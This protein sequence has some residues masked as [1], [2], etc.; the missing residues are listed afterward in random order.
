MNRLSR[1][2][3]ALLAA[4][5]VVVSLRFPS[6]ALAQQ[7]GEGMDRSGVLDIRSPEEHRVFEAL[8]CT[9]G[10]PREAISTCTC[11]FAAGFRQEVREMMAKGM[12]LEDIKAEWVR[13]HGPEALSVPPNGGGNRFVYI[14]PLLLIAGM[15][16]VAI[17]ALRRFRAHEVATT[18]AAT[19]KKGKIAPAARDDY[20]QK[21]DDELKRLD[22]DDDE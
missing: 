2:I 8:Q 19:G 7:L 13:R 1:A 16:A 15:A 5:A 11:G 17:S 12:S 9:C 14:V 4:A 3:F 6:L 22:Q 10:C 20:D 21:L 18:T